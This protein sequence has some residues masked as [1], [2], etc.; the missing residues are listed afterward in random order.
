MAD[1]SD[2]ETALNSQFSPQADFMRQQSIGA[3]ID[4]RTKALQLQY[5]Q[6]LPDALAA[7]SS[8]GGAGS[9]GTGASS[10]P[11]SSDPEDW[12]HITPG[13]D[14]DSGLGVNGPA[15]TQHLQANYA[16]IPG[17]VYSSAEWN[18]MN[19]ASMA[20][21]P[22][23]AKMIADRHQMQID[24]VNQQRLNGA[25]QKYNNLFGVVT[26]PEGRALDALSLVDPDAANQLKTSEASDTDVRHFAAQMSGALHTA[27]RM[28]TEYRKE[29]GV[30]VDAA[31]KQPIP[32][33]NL[34]VGL[35]PE[36]ISALKKEATKLITTKVDGRDVQVPTWKGEGADSADGW[37]QQHANVAY[38]ARHG[39][40]PVG[41]VDSAGGPSGGMAA[42]AGSSPPWANPGASGNANPQPQ[43]GAQPGNNP[44]QAQ[45]APRPS[46]Q[47]PAPLDPALKT[48]LSDNTYRVKMPTVPKGGSLLPDEQK[49]RDNIVESRNSLLQDSSEATQAAAQ[50]L[51]YNKAAKAIM[52]S[53]GAT[54]GAYGGLMSQA[55]KY[56]PLGNVD[57]T[58][59]Q[60]VAKYLGNAALAAAKGTYGAKMTQ[61]EVGLQLNELSPSTHMTADAINDLL[62]ENIRNAQYTVD[63]GKRAEKFLA[64]GNDPRRFK[65]W[66]EKYFPQAQSVNAHSDSKS[67][68]SVP[69]KGTGAAPVRISS[70]SEYANIP[71]G[72]RYIAP[73]G[74]IRV[75]G[76]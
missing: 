14:T 76:Q 7:S 2:V 22:E 43:P 23:M 42:P 64:A 48:A 39:V 38:Q 68:S 59:Y 69:P 11:N 40:A 58:N 55:S 70:S 12:A 4:N 16:P 1:I 13:Q 54:V 65:V 27:A 62:G 10:L 66:N 17:K 47:Q 67:D 21:K 45:Q 32:G 53:K 36:Q 52:D 57:A 26:A 5:L 8:G 19:A 18:A 3:S 29:D 49:E 34:A 31:T 41:G 51:T 72:V 74:K 33:Y 9:G 24:A 44:P 20:G 61:S 73:D 60:E 28:P 63:S 71:R 50:S 30:A 25:Q 15:M 6:Q 37:V 75:K 56:L 35:G 46:P